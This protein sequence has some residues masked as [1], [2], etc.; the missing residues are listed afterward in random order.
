MPSVA[1]HYSG[2]WAVVAIFNAAKI[3]NL[4]TKFDLL[5][6]REPLVNFTISNDVPLEVKVNTHFQIT[7]QAFFG[8]PLP[9]G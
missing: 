8:Q 1:C 6:T 2:D 5:T 7:C 3:S 4:T 9:I